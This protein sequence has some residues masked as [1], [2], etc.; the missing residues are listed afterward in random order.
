MKA[1]FQ[2]AVLGFS[3]DLTDPDA[4]WLPVGTVV[5]GQSGGAVVASSVALH[6]D[7]EICS[8]LETRYGFRLDPISREVLQDIPRLIERQFSSEL[9]RQTTDERRREQ[10]R[11]RGVLWL[12]HHGLRNSLHVRSISEVSEEE[13]RDAADLAGRAGEKAMKIWTEHFDAF[14]SRETGRT[15]SASVQ[16]D[17][18]KPRMGTFW[19]ILAN[20][21]GPETL[22][23]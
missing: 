15:E 22:V 3:Y 7:D 2:E 16:T 23:R 6:F 19:P 9:E 10:A 17:M 20:A 13:I 11:Q 1:T 5:T 14:L 8:L 18:V 21:G 12:L 4:A